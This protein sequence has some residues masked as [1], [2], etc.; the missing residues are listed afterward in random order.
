MR[1]HNYPTDCCACTVGEGDRIGVGD[2]HAGYGAICAHVCNVCT[3]CSVCA[4]EIMTDQRQQRRLRLGA[5]VRWQAAAAAAARRTRET[6]PCGVLSALHALC[7]PLA[8]HALAF[9]AG[10]HVRICRPR[11]HDGFFSLCCAGT[12][13]RGWLPLAGR[14]GRRLAA[15]WPMPCRQNTMAS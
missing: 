13:N 1:S 8:L 7:A 12:D 15:D 9:A 10:P 2:R 4:R 6:R 3:E 11:S 5:C 14:L